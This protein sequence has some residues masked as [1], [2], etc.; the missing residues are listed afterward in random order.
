MMKI[1]VVHNTYQ[2]HGGEDVVAEQEVAL[3]R[4]YGHEVIPYMRSNDELRELSLW[5]KMALPKRIVWAEDAVQDLQQ[6][7]QYERPQVAHFHNTFAMISPAAYYVCQRMGV[8]VVQ[9]LHNYRFLCPR[10]DFFRA[11]RICEE[12]L[13]KRLP[14]PGIVHKCY[15]GSR[16]HTAAVAA[17]LTVHGLLKTWHRQVNFYIALTEFVKRKFI[18]GGF[19]AE[20]IIVKPNFLAPDPGRRTRAGKY[21]LF[22]GRLSPEKRVLTLLY[23]WKKL[24]GITLKVVGGGPE[25][26]AI[27]KTIRELNLDNVELLGQC[28]RDQ[29]IAL[30]KEALFLVFPS[31]WYETFGLVIIEAFA[32][33]VPVIAARRGSVSELVEDQKTGLLFSPGDV[34]DLAE[35]IRWAMEHPEILSR[36]GENARRLYEEKYMEDRNYRMLVAIYERAAGSSLQSSQ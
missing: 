16:M 5:K 3:L 21:A 23:T 17:L 18:E 7:L 26:I 25:E 2:R 12:C 9:T 20:R 15:H 33:G 30:M 32:C 29:V 4:K 14:W 10:A 28:P 35:K 11:G 24:R 36:M 27:E 6:L 19:P 22:V 1:L 34:D 8:A 31:E 13:E